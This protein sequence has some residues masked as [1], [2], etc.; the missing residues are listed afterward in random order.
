MSVICR[1]RT[2]S[3]SFDRKRGQFSEIEGCLWGS[4]LRRN[5]VNMTYERNLS[6][7]AENLKSLFREWIPKRKNTVYTLRVLADELLALKQ[8]VQSAS[9]RKLLF[10]CR[11]LFYGCR[12]RSFLCNR[13]SI[14]FCLLDSCWNW[15]GCPTCGWNQVEDEIHFLFSCPK[16]SILRNRFSSK[17]KNHLSC[18]CR[19][20]WIFFVCL[21]F[22]IT[23]S[24]AYM[25]F[26]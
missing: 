4:Q 5:S 20:P 10:S 6:R 7:Q 21:C 18:C 12:I 2:Q 9:C 3:R 22:R 1:Q 23:F 17:I 13:W 24:H 25:S 19:I 16:Y 8:R 26:S 15:R 14:C 11:V